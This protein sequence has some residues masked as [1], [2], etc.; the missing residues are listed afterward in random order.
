MSKLNMSIPHDLTQVEALNRIQRLLGEVRTKFA[1]K[2]R[3][4]HEE[5]DGNS[6]KFSFS[7]MGFAVSGI[8]TVK[9]SQI[10]LSG[11]LP[12]AAALFKKKIETA[13]RTQA[14]SLLA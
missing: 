1:D 14:E 6:G 9:P 4:L 8:L 10:E 13:I 11:N 7:A 3:D 2:I 12:L 5:W